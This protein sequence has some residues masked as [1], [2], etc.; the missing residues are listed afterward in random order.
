MS[1]SPAA[2]ILSAFGYYTLIDGCLSPS[3]CEDG[4]FPSVGCDG[5]C[6]DVAAFDCELVAPV[7]NLLGVAL[8]LKRR[9]SVERFGGDE[10]VEVWGVGVPVPCDDNLVDG[11]VSWGS[12]LGVLVGVEAHNVI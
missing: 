8:C 6:V 10:R 5:V 9:M 2:V 12:S 3:L 4:V 7:P 1:V 11:D